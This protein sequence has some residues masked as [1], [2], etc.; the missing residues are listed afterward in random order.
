MLDHTHSYFFCVC[1][2]CSPCTIL[3]YLDIWGEIMG[4]QRPPKQHRLQ[5]LPLE[6]YYTSW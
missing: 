5:L 4:Y 6:T 3:I 1:D 2:Q